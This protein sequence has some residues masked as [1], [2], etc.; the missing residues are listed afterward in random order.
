MIFRSELAIL[1]GTVCITLLVSQKASI[2]HTIIPAG[3]LAAAIGLITTVAVDSFFWQQPFLWPEWAAFYFNTI[4]GKSSEWGVSPWHFYF[5]SAIPRLMLNPFTLLVCIPVSLTTKQTLSFSIR[6]LTPLLA[7]VA[8]FSVLPHKEWRFIIYIIPGL[9]AVAAA[10]ASAIWTR[11]SRSMFHRLVA[12]ALLGS[13]VVSFAA[14]AGML[15]LSALNY[16]GAFA[17]ARLH[18]LADG[19]KPVVSVHL[20]NLACQTGVTRFLQ[21][22]SDLSETAGCAQSAWFYDKTDS[23]E[24]SQTVGSMFYDRFDYLLVEELSH[25]L[26]L[27]GT[28]DT[29]DTVMGFGGVGIVRDEDGV[30]T[31][32]V[33]STTEVSLDNAVWKMGERWLKN[34]V[35]GGRWLAIKMVPKIRI[36]RNNVR[37]AM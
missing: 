30:S 23:S 18:T 19:S 35:T 2:T 29:V 33:G 16:P 28:W 26:S 6:V 24:V 36:L 14:S 25:E 7:F 4:Q 31:D 13:V 5:S 12:L 22:P 3:L 17:L 11:R 32:F 20:G 15:L 27:L 21:L 34:H 10:G 1:V 37:A 8:I 9:T